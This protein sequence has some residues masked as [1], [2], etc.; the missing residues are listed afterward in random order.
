MKTNITGVK[1]SFLLP[2][3]HHSSRAKGVPGIE[4]FQRWGSQARPCFAKRRPINYPVVLEALK[5]WLD[6]V[7]LVMGEQR[8]FLNASFITLP[9]HDIHRI[10][11]HAFDQE[12]A[13]LAHHYMRT[14]KVTQR[15]RERADMIVVTMRDRDRVELL[16]LDQGIQRQTGTPF[17]FGM[18]PGIHQQA[19]AIDLDKPGRSTDIRVGI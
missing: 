5:L 12:V 10:M 13:Q 18:N 16:V 8:V 9:C 19:V 6:V 4:E 3:H 11:Q 15:H 1:K 2:T 17:A 14:R 7:H